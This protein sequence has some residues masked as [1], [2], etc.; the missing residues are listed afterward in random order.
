[1]DRRIR[2]ALEEAVHEVG[3]PE[4]LAFKL[5]RWFREIVSGNEEI[6]DKQS[7]DRHLEGLYRGV[8]GAVGVAEPDDK[9]AKR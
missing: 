7:V 1:M 9:S 4:Q 6:S 3:Q 2:T 8:V 5:S